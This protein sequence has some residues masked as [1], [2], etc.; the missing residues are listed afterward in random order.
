MSS[1]MNGQEKH[2]HRYWHPHTKHSRKM[3]KRLSKVPVNTIQ[4][5]S[6]L[7]LAMAMAVAVAIY[8][9]KQESKSTDLREPSQPPFE[10]TS[11]Q[12][13]APHPRQSHF[14]PFPPVRWYR[15][16]TS[17]SFCSPDNTTWCGEAADHQGQR[18][19]GGTTL[20]RNSLRCRRRSSYP[21]LHR[22]KYNTAAPRG[23]SSLALARHQQ[24]AL[25][26][27][28]SL[29]SACGAWTEQPSSWAQTCGATRR[30]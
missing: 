22:R 5:P 15:H 9:Y 16:P 6:F 7:S 28:H 1:S 25:M 26:V 23:R 12:L 2:Q 27:E 10:N 24:Q 4:L 11:Q 18:R 17:A 13:N 8:T 21:S 3:R 20:S 19:R 29:W 14:Q 30:L